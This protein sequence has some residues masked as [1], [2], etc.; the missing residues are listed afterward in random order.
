MPA[1]IDCKYVCDP[2]NFMEPS[3]NLWCPGYTFTTTSSTSTNIP[4]E[5]GHEFETIIQFK[6]LMGVFLFVLATLLI[7]MPLVGVCVCNKKKIDA[8]LKKFGDRIPIKFPTQEETPREVQLPVEDN[9]PTSV[10]TGDDRTSSARRDRL[11][12]GD[13]NPTSRDR[14]PTLDHHST[15]MECPATG[16]DRPLTTI[17]PQTTGDVTNRHYSDINAS[18]RDSLTTDAREPPDETS[19]LLNDPD[20][21]QLNAVPNQSN[22]EPYSS[23]NNLGIPPPAGY[24]A[25]STK[26]EENINLRT[27]RGRG[28]GNQ[29]EFTYPKTTVV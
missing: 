4:P 10:E 8:F 16:E 13:H 22:I 3:C 25:I 15:E 2:A 12:T 11:A 17:N 28:E 24:I 29:T 14:L 6:L 26:G 9:L 21:P 23:Q 5:Y 7:A 27:L 19:A 20:Q 1:A 18:R